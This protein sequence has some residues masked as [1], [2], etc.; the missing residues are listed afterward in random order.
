MRNGLV[1]FFIA[2]LGLAIIRV[3]LGFVSVPLGLVMPAGLLVTAIF[4]AVPVFAVY[5][6]SSHKWTPKLAGAFVAIGLVSHL[7]LGFLVRQQVFGVGIIAALMGAVAQTG[8]FLWCIGL[9]ALLATMLKDKNLLL[10]VSAFLAGFDIFLVLTPIGIT[11]QIMK[12]APEVL[13]AVGLNIPKPAATPTMGPVQPFAFVGPADFLFMGMFFVA[14]HRFGMRSRDT[15]L[16]MIPTIL[17]YLLLSLFVG[18]IPLLVPVGLVVLVVNWP[19][20]KLNKEEKVS[21]LALVVILTGLIAFGATRPKPQPAPS[22]SEP[23]QAPA[24]PAGSL[25]PGVEDRGPSAPP[26]S[27]ESTPNPP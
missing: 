26:T 11:Q 14:I 1:V 19:E 15:A 22:P 3:L 6:A 8:F 18:A 5:A 17:I 12:K 20:F 9:G 7:G 13:P 16:W 23:V 2:L 10:P 25:G 21:T 24:G 4:L 27:Q